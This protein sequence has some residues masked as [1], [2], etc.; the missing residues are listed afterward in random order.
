MLAIDRNPFL[1]C[2]RSAWRLEAIS[3]IGSD[4][5]ILRQRRDRLEFELTLA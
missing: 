3:G 2:F 5:G 4:Q 1:T